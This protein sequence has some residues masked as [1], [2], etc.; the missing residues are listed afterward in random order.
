MLYSRSPAGKVSRLGRKKYRSAERE[1]DFFPAD[2]QG[3]A[4]RPGGERLPLL[5]RNKGVL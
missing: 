1:D 5:Q 4:L 3:P 2:P